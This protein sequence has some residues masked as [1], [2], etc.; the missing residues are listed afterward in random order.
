MPLST[1]KNALYN[2]GYRTLSVLLPIVT[3]PYLARTVGQEGTGLYAY[4]WSISTI[5]VL[6]GMLGLENY[7]VRAIARVREN[8]E[9][10]N[11]VFSEIYQMQ[12]LTAG[13]ALALY[14]GYVCFVAEAEQYIAAWLTLMSVS[15]LVN[16]DWLLMG[17]DRFRPIALRN[18]F[19]KLMATAGVFLLVRSKEDLWRYALIWGGSTLVGCLS[20]WIGLSRHVRF[21][22][23][24][25]RSALQHLRP[26]AVL[27][28]SVIA[29]QVYRTMDK[30]M[31][32][33]I[34]GMAE[35]GLYENAEKIVYC[36]SGFISAIGTVMLP[37]V[38][39]MQARGET[40]AVKRH[41]ALSME[42]ILCMTCAM[43]FGVAAIATDFAPLF[44]GDDFAYSGVLMI[45]LA[46][47]LIMIGFA[48]VVRT[49]WVLPQG[50]DPIFVRSVC[51][52]AVVNLAV[53]GALI[54]S[55]GAMGAVVGTLAAEFA[56]PF[57]QW[58]MLRRELPY[59]RFLG[60]TATYCGLGLIMLWTV[61]L[62][63]RWLPWKGWTG[64]AV[65]V[66]AGAGIYALSCLVLWRLTGRR[67]LLRAV[68][69][70]R[71]S[72]TGKR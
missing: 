8:A 24:S 22:P 70:K 50:R 51:A 3:A 23:V 68:S 1:R 2:V 59:R 37:K 28:L 58:L 41:M 43:A 71:L 15:C 17:L 52:G 18:T 21:R 40:E 25:W 7:G 19:V 39:A 26:C 57:T 66:A 32:G 12:L 46:F 14:L 6:L 34:S 10:R 53:N 45:P 49:Q 4:A 27:F 44:F 67:D 56:V 61:R 16:L 13:A 29:V 62:V 65:E 63:A 55:M 35:N 48:N 36:L 54:P 64:M 42:L 31:V 5:F 60:M 11:R 20:C 33:A 72:R 30:I 69:G 9:D 47:T 38:S